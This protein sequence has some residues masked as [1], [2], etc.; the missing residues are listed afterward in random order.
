M[1]QDYSI[2]WLIVTLVLLFLLM[3]A[4][5]RKGKL[6]L[7]AA[8]T[9]SL[10]GIAILAGTGYPGILM[11]VIFFLLGVGATAHKKT[12]KMAVGHNAGHPERRT[13]S[14]VFANGGVAAIVSLLALFDPSHLALYTAI[15][16]GSLASATADTLSSELG[17]VYGRN[18]YNILSWKRE[19]KGLDGVVSLEGTVLGALGA[20]CIGMVFGLAYG[21]DS[22][23]AFIVLAGIIGNLVDSILGASFERKRYIGNNTVNFLNTTTG[24]LIVFL[25]LYTIGR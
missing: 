20:C 14:Q 13:A 9:G 16:G 2:A 25:L 24:A 18:F 15:V 17:M 7:S 6:T 5:V 4:S 12:S 19:A 21:L 22:R 11:L 10:L 8:L 1:G 23:M 3:A